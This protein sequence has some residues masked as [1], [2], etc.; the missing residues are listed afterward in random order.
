M[1]RF[2][3]K[4]PLRQALADYAEILGV[5]VTGE[6]IKKTPFGYRMSI[7]EGDFRSTYRR[8]EEA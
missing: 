4:I 3:Q 5:E 6:T 8:N 1:H 2:V 7:A